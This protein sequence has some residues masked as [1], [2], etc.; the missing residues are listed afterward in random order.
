MLLAHAAAPATIEA[1]VEK[2]GIVISNEAGMADIAVGESA[3]VAIYLVLEE[4]EL[5]SS[6]EAD[7]ELA[8]TD[9]ADV[10]VDLGRVDPG[11]APLGEGS[12]TSVF[13][14]I[15]DGL[16]QIS[17]T[18]DDAGGVSLVADLLVASNGT[19]GVFEVL[20]AG[21]AANGDS[22]DPPFFV[23]VPIGTMEGEALAT[24][25]VPEATATSGSLAAIVALTLGRA[26][27]TAVGRRS[28]ETSR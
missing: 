18:R 15:G 12:W 27:A 28:N 21:G 7:F 17:L 9:L 4:S 25:R 10:T 6:F 5:A 24:I 16:A 19:E 3:V 14:N 11:L 23:V 2:D 22:D 20:F 8:G 26:L 1:D 13:S